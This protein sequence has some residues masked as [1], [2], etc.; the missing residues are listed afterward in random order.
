MKKWDPETWAASVA[1]IVR[2]FVERRTVELRGK[3]AE[4][5][6]RPV[7]DPR[8]I[9]DAAAQN[10]QS[11]AERI[12]ALPV[13]LALDDVRALIDQSTDALVS[14]VAS[15]EAR[16]VY[17]PDVVGTLRVELSA[18]LSAANQAQIAALPAPQKGDRGEPGTPG[19]AGRSVTL[20]EVRPFVEAWLATWSSGFERHATDLLQK[21]VDRFPKPR[22]GLDGLGFDD[23]EILFDGERTTTYRLARGEQVK[24]WTFTDPRLIDRG[25]YVRGR[26]YARGDGVTWSGHYWIAQRATEEPPVE[27]GDAWRLAVRRGRD[28]KGLK[29]EPGAAGRPGKDGT[30]Q[31]LR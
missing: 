11:F 17:D 19:E 9:V 5:E 20:E 31:W 14:R 28:G 18:E 29:G 25:V 8:Y 30:T 21:A 26:P 13:P 23:L 3:I 22:D 7:F 4:L 16:P 2:E 6:A 24:E 27:A 12:A 15:L 10:A 1:A